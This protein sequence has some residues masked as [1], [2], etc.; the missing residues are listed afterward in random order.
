[1]IRNNLHHELDTEAHTN[2]DDK[3]SAKKPQDLTSGRFGFFF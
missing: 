1:M 2:R 3:M